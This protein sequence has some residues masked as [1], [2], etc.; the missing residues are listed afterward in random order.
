MEK[1]YQC[2]KCDKAFTYWDTDIMDNIMVE[3]LLSFEAVNEFEAVDEF[4]QIIKCQ[5][6]WPK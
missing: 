2:N 4:S 6:D 1:P 5:W 3:S